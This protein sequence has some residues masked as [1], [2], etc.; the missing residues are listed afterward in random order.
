[1]TTMRLGHEIGN[2]IYILTGPIEKAFNFMGQ[3]FAKIISR[4]IV[5]VIFG[6][7][8]YIVYPGDISETPLA[9]LTLKSIAGLFVSILFGFIAFR[10]L[11]EK[12]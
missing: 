2:W 3:T 10:A 5:P 1:M 11:F 6:T 4:L 9:Q 8:A 12:E 7:I